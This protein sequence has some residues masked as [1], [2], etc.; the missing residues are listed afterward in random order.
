[1]K[2][3]LYENEKMRKKNGMKKSV[4]CLI[5]TASMAMSGI[6]VAAEGFSL[7]A[8]RD[9]ETLFGA[10]LLTFLERKEKENFFFA[11]MRRGVAA[12]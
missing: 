7:T 8:Q 6:P 4:L 12:K 11:A 2:K 9:P 5:L 10:S 3:K 1:M